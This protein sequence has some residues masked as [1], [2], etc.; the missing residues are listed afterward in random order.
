[1]DRNK[2]NELNNKIDD[3]LDLVSKKAEGLMYQNPMKF[4]QETKTFLNYEEENTND[5]FA[6]WVN[7][8]AFLDRY[9]PTIVKFAKENNQ[10]V[11]DFY[12]DMVIRILDK[13]ELYLTV[14]NGLAK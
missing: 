8:L 1:M 6:H 7:S 10:Q 3:I 4:L 2:L 13:I 9:K 12:N 14:G 5:V 11:V